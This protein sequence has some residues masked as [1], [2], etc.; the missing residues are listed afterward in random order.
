MKIKLNLSFRQEK[1]FESHQTFEPHQTFESYQESVRVEL[2]NDNLDQDVIDQI[3]SELHLTIGQIRLHLYD[4]FEFQ[5]VRL[6][7]NGEELDNDNNTLADYGWT[8]GLCGRI[9]VKVMR[10]NDERNIE[11]PPY[12]EY[13]A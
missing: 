3:D 8:G 1:T 11:Y 12:S 7:Y 9:I 6:H 2:V 10:D 4:N 5:R 13:E